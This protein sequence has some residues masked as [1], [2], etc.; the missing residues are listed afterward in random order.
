M[1]DG[2]NGVKLEVAQ[3]LSL[4][5]LRLTEVENG[6]NSLNEWAGEVADKTGPD[7][8][9]ADLEEKEA[10]IAEV[11]TRMEEAV[12]SG[13]LGACARPSDADGEFLNEKVDRLQRW[14]KGMYD[15][16]CT[17]DIRNAERIEGIERLI[18]GSMPRTH[19]REA[20]NSKDRKPLLEH[21]AVQS[22]AQLG[23]NK[24]KVKEWNI[25]FVNCMSQV[26]PLYEKAL[27]CL[28]KLADAEAMPDMEVGW[29]GHNGLFHD[30][31]NLNVDQLDKDLK[32]VLVEK[33]SGTVH[34]EV[35]NGMPKGGVYVYTDIYKWLTETSGP[36]LMEHVRELM[37][38][39]KVKHESETTARAE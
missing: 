39:E 6:Y 32:C 38:P 20:T 25:K 29:P 24:D 37:H 9:R 33:A 15:W 23:D 7:A 21:K 16:A 8:L 35:V 17:E 18:E 30:I 34:T 1:R 26:D 31:P 13:G 4:H 36:G 19:R 14:V 10:R 11:E 22:I 3:G 5:C 12:S 2:L 28:M 27:S